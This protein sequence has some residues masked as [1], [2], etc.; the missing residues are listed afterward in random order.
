RAHDTVPSI[1]F[2][3]LSPSYPSVSFFL[4]CYAAHRYLPSFPTRR[5]SDLAEIVM[6]GEGQ[7]AGGATVT[8]ADP[9]SGPCARISP[10]NCG[11]TRS[12]E[13]TSEL[14]SLTNLV[15]RLLLEKKNKHKHYK[16]SHVQD[17]SHRDSLP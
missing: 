7:W 4:Y 1:L 2:I 15:C 5:S 6:S 13:H 12:E 3:S 9:C 11:S 10:R 8:R 17:G 14:Q 16:S